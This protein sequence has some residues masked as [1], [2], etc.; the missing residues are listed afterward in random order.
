MISTGQLLPWH[1]APWVVMSF[2]AGSILDAPLPAVLTVAALAAWLGT[3]RTVP[4]ILAAV[5]PQHSQDRRDVWFRLLN[6]GKPGLSPSAPSN[7]D[8]SNVSE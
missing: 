4:T 8:S 2:T 6:K 3:M 1:K 5:T 7:D